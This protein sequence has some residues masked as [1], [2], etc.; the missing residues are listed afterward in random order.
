MSL[1]GS[2][3]PLLS[4]PPTASQPT[5]APIALVLVAA[6]LPAGVSWAL[7]GCCPKQLSDKGLAASEPGVQGRGTFILGRGRTNE[8]R[9]PPFKRHEL[10]RG[11]ACAFDWD[12]VRGGFAY[13]RRLLGLGSG[14]SWTTYWPMSLA[15]VSL[16]PYLAFDSSPTVF[17]FPFADPFVW[18]LLDLHCTWLLLS[19]K[20]I[21]F[22][23]L[24]P[25]IP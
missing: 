13:N 16:A 8:P 21:P 17:R 9:R 18:P 20:H 14:T 19:H 25:P 4:D 15:S 1:D 12:S 3:S 5:R 23:S 24:F 11:C 7:L 6:P 10:R 22:F 2:P